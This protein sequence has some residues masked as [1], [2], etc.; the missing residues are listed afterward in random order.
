MCFS[1]VLQFLNS[2]T[3]LH[4]AL[5]SW[6]LFPI[7]QFI[8]SPLPPSLLSIYL[9][10]FLLFCWKHL[11]YAI[12][13]ALCKG[14][15]NWGYRCESHGSCF[16]LAHNNFENDTLDTCDF[17]HKWQCSSGVC[18]GGWG[19]EGVRSSSDRPQLSLRKGIVVGRGDFR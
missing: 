11:L 17:V 16:H 4:L 2:F 1:F 10:S 8:H 7:V 15:Q 9:I 12:C 3:F 6:T 14:T 19:K 13:Q 5:D 18:C